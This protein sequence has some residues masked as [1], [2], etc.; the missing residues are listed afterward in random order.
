MNCQEMNINCKKCNNYKT[1]LVL[2]KLKT[3]ESNQNL[4]AEKLIN[5]IENQNT[6][7]IQMTSIIEIQNKILELLENTTIAT[8]SNSIESEENI[9]PVEVVENGLVVSE[10]TKVFEEK[11]GLFGKKKIVEVKK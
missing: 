3:I 10:N 9:H 6:F 1:C 4:F 8:V 5:I 2:F 7:S 11:K